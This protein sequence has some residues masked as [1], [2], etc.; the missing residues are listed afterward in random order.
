MPI[1]RGQIFDTP[2]G[3]SLRLATRLAQQF[4]VAAAHQSE[5][6]LHQTDGPVAQV[7]GLPGP[8]GNLL[9][10]EQ[11]RGDHPVGATRGSRVERAQRQSQAL[12]ALQGKLM[13]WGTGGAPVS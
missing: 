11:E 5:T 7:M 1:G 10:P 9:G 2:E 13:R 4:A 8:F 12:S 3:Y 6:T